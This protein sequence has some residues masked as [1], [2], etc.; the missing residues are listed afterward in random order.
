M[1]ALHALHAL[2]ACMHAC[3][4]T[5]FELCIEFLRQAALNKFYPRAFVFVECVTDPRFTQ[6]LSFESAFVLGTAPWFLYG[7]T[8]G[9]I[10]GWNASEFTER[11][12]AAFQQIPP[13]QAA[14]AFVGGLLLVNAI[15]QCGCEEPSL[16]AEQ[17]R[18]IGG[19]RTLYNDISFDVEGQNT[20]PPV[21]YKLSY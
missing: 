12:T 21:S 2:H 10:T 7:G 20:A 1:H 3:H 14:A 9:K 16:V 6:L 13:Y 15:E 5:F 19:L 4:S 17:L 11:Y 18:Q 8:A